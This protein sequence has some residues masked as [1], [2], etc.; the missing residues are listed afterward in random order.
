M[1]NANL[2]EIL[3]LSIKKGSEDMFLASKNKVEGCVILSFHGPL[4]SL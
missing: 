1:S 2:S 3:L 4:Y